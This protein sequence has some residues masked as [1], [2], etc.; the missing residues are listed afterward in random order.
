[1]TSVVNDFSG[2]SN[3]GRE[4]GRKTRVWLILYTVKRPFLAVIF[5]A[6]DIRLFDRLETNE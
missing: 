5:R 1:M 3:G 2:H 6:A 4:S